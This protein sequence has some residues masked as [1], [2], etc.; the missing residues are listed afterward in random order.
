MTEND[1]VDGRELTE[2]DEAGS[3]DL[4][5]RGLLALLVNQQGTESAPRHD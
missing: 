5:L 1:R 2:R 4:L 3:D